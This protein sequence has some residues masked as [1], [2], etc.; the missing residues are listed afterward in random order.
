M[1]AIIC[2]FGETSCRFKTPVGNTP[3]S[4]AGNDPSAGTVYCRDPTEN[5]TRCPSAVILKYPNASELSCE[6]ISVF[7]PVSTELMCT[8]LV[9]PKSDGIAAFVLSVLSATRYQIDSPISALR[10]TAW[11]LPSKVRL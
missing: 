6:K 10:R 3:N 8:C 11:P 2:P 7:W 5:T 1:Y 4:F 9:D